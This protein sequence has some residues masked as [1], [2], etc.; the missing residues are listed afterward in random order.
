MSTL[1]DSME[2]DVPATPADTGP[3]AALHAP[4]PAAS[5]AIDAYAAIDSQYVYRGVALREHPSPIFAASASARGWF[6][7]V[8]SA[9]VDGEEQARYDDAHGH[10]WDVDAS[11]GYGAAFTDM[12]QWSLAGARIIDI[13]DRDS[14]VHDYYEWRAS[15]Y[16]SNVARAQFAYSPDYKE[17]G[18]SSWNGEVA[19]S[20][21]L[22]DALRAEV[23][24]GRSHGAGYADN[25]YTY[26]WVGVSTSLWRTQW[27][28]RWID[29]GR[30]GRYVVGSDRGGSRFVISANWGLHV[31]P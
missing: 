10:E 24:V 9:Y 13:G 1:L 22:T 30:G 8:W 16:A 18:W 14:D 27:D 23:G 25:D 5:V 11:I 6:V 3:I 21:P 29:A 28:A 31:L 7:D 20:H 15:L 2:P 17:R 26:G 4:A 19:A 12:W